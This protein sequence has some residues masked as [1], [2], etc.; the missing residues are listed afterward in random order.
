M[1]S[2]FGD[3][4]VGL[5]RPL[6]A[7]NGPHW[8]A[9]RAVDAQRASF[10]S[11]E[12]SSA[13]VNAYWEN[14]RAMAAAARSAAAASGG[15]RKG[16]SRENL[17]STSRHDAQHNAELNKSSIAMGDERLVQQRGGPYHADSYEKPNRVQPSLMAQQ[18]LA[19]ERLSDAQKNKNVSQQSSVGPRKTRPGGAMPAVS[20]GGGI[21][22]NVVPG[23]YMFTMQ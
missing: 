11:S 22:K 20:G 13:G 2:T 10:S 6:Q 23:G 12:S 18:K 16:S 8:G 7:V 4:A 5:A 19:A 17:F 9:A 15:A 21:L 14:V 3:T 1:R